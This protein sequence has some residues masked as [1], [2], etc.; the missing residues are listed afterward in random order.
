MPSFRRFHRVNLGAQYNTGPHNTGPRR[1]D[2]AVA[3]AA[4]PARGRTLRPGR[5]CGCGEGTPDRGMAKAHLNA[6][7]AALHRVWAR[8]DLHRRAMAARAAR[9][10]SVRGKHGRKA[11]GF[12]AGWPRLRKIAIGA[13]VVAALAVFSA[14]ALWWRLGSGPLSVDIVTPW[15]TAAVEERL[16]GGHR[17]EVGGTQLER[18]ED[19]RAALRLRDIIVRDPD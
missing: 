10:R 2:E 17:I 16:G 12:A 6:G 8:L 9:R 11:G 7:L 4:I 14:A 5:G 3:K 13:G 1:R 19:G 15:L 18:T